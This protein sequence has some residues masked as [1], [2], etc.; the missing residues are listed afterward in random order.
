MTSLPGEAAIWWGD[1]KIAL[2]AA[3]GLS[4]DALHIHLGILLFLLFALMTRRGLDRWLPWLLLLAL[5]TAN[6]VL[7]LHQP[8]GS[9]EKNMAAGVHD[10]V[11]TMFAPTLLMLFLRWRR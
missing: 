4:K 8:A 2:S 3:L 1:V 10:I 5:E 11:N 9:M 7:D 6:E